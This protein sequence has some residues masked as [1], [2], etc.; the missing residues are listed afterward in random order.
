MSR[1]ESNL[2]EIKL[3][4]SNSINDKMNETSIYTMIYNNN[5]NLFLN[6]NFLLRSNR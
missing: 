1:F 3:N 4:L 6:Y 2:D 5:N